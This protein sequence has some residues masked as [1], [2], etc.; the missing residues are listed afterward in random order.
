MDLRD[1]IVY[2]TLRRILFLCFGERETA[3]VMERIEEELSAQGCN[4]IIFCSDTDG[5]FANLQ[6]RD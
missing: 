1:E 5:E 6:G 4:A 2:P 3:L